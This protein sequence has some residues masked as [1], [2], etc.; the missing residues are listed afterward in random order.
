MRRLWERLCAFFFGLL[1]GFVV[2]AFAY[3]PSRQWPV[4]F[5]YRYDTKVDSADAVIMMMGNVGDR[6]PHCARLIQKGIAPKIVFVEAEKDEMMQLG[7]RPGDGQMSLNY[8]KKLG[9][10]AAAILFD[11]TASVSSSM[12]ELKADFKLIKERLPGARRV[13][14]CTS[15]YHASRTMWAAQKVNEHTFEL[16]SIPSHRPR[17]WYAKEFD[18]L[19]VFNEY[20]K[21]LY[22]LLHY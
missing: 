3:R 14:L 5:L 18:F 6:T 8:L 21:W 20:L 7:Y 15:W 1:V 10:P 22:Y 12:E 19:M 13:I 2:L 17:I 4:D 11:S 9:V 16:K